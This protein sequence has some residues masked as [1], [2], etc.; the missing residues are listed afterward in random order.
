[1]Q[2]RSGD[3]VFELADTFRAFA[4]ATP[5]QISLVRLITQR[6]AALVGDTCVVSLADIDGNW[7]EPSTADARDPGPAAALAA[8]LVDHVGRDGNGLTGRVLKSGDPI[9]VPT[10]DTETLAARAEPAFANVVREFGICGFLAVPLR[11]PRH[12][13]GVMS[14]QRYKREPY[15]NRDLALALTIADHAALAIANAQLVASLQREL[16]ERAKAEAMLLQAQKMD[17]L[18]RLAGGVAH[19]FNNLLTVILSYCSML[20][21]ELPRGT[22]PAQEVAQIDHAARRA[23]DLTRQLLAFSRR[24]VLEPEPIELGAIVHDMAPMIHRL[25]GEDIE[26]R[27]AVGDGGA[28]VMA[29]SGQLEQVVINLVVNARDAM[30]RGGVL[31]VETVRDAGEVVLAISDT[32]AGMDDHTKAHL[33]EPFYTTKAIGKG[34]GLGLS[35]VMGIVEQSGGRLA[36]DSELGRGTTIRVHLP[37]TTR[38]VTPV[39]GVPVRATA[40]QLAGRVL[41]VEDDREVRQLVGDV[42]ARAGY[43]V[44]HAPD[45]EH[46]LALARAGGV[47]DL[48]VTDVIMPRMSGRELATRFA[49]LQPAA[50]VLYMSGYTDDKL[51]THGVLERGVV[52]VQKPLTPDVL[53]ERVRQMLGTRSR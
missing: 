25:V 38:T 24:Q 3:H 41:V 30:E 1:V 27:I 42:L 8:S 50:Q 52:L 7:T 18:G 44:L 31:T 20:A 40:V 28:V 14:L 12:T 34:T 35:T 23:A 19:D 21:H 13:L 10:I 15:T 36:V 48:L 6:G 32:G 46:A 9:M 51:G 26:L 5:D 53:L 11:G 37:I 49:E 16:V 45:G 47:V 4:A 39:V 29:D 33:F 43:D 17:A 2:D 22:R